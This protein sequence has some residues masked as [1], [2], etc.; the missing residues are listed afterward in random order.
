MEEERGEKMNE[1]YPFVLPPL[2][3]RYS[4]LEPYLGRLTIRLHHDTLFQG[5]VTRL[6]AALKNYPRFQ[7]WSIQRLIVENA[8]LP[9]DIRTT[10]YNNAGGVYNH[11]IYFDAMTPNYRNPSRSM[12]N[13][14][15]QSFGSFD[16]FKKQM[17]IA[18]TGVF[19]SGWAWLVR[20]RRNLLQIITTKNQDTPLPEGLYPILPL[21]VWE[22]S[23]YL[24]YYAARDE[25]IENWFHLI[26][27]D[28]VEKRFR[29]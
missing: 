8:K 21:D 4:A 11:T 22:H 6:N 19:G 12:L 27:W 9:E 16:N 18:G 25:Y 20:N 13:I 1:S 29:D 28:Y 24:Q 23:Y 7:N 17:S 10:V 2:P 26:R 15:Q 14:I 3:Y 5:Y